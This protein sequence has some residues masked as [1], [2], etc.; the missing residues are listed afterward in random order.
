MTSFP[1]SGYISRARGRPCRC[2]CCCF[3]G[4]RSRCGE[5]SGRTNRRTH[6]QERCAPRP[7]SS[8]AAR[9][10]AAGSATTR[11]GVARRP[12]SPC[13]APVSWRFCSARGKVSWC[14]SR[15]KG[16][17]APPPALPALALPALRSRH[18]AASRAPRHLPSREAICF[19]TADSA[20]ASLLTQPSGY[21]PDSFRP[22][23]PRGAGPPSAPIPCLGL[24]SRLPQDSHRSLLW[25]AKVTGG[26]GRAAGSPFASLPLHVPS[27]PRLLPSAFAPLFSCLSVLLSLFSL[28]SGA[29]SLSLHLP[30]PYDSCPRLPHPLQSGSFPKRKG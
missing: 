12:G 25:L 21:G 4:S 8:S 16:P 17:W 22:S 28:T 2:R 14:G 11:L 9:P 23:R 24:E 18:H 10:Q 5:A 30:A 15:G 3:C 26:D 13:A 7:R 27:L 19:S 29:H 6:T 1:G 20:T